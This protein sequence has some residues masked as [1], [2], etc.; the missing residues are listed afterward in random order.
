MTR[1]LFLGPLLLTLAA[2]DRGADERPVV[3]DAIEQDGNGNT[4]RVL[5][6]SALAQGLVRFD[7]AG[8]VEPAIAERWNMVDDGRSYI[9]RL[10]TATWSDGRPV[11]AD[12][13][14]TALRRAARTGAGHRLT[15][16]LRSIDEIV[17]M[18][19]QV[20]EIRLKRPNTELLTLLAQP[21]LAVMHGAQGSGPMRRLR[22][23]G[24][25]LRAPVDSDA[26]APVPADE[27]RLNG[28]RAALAV[29]RFGAKRSDLVLGGA[30]ADWPIVAAAGL[31]T[32]D[33]R[34]DP[35]RGLFGFAFVGRDGFLAAPLNRAAVA[36]AIQTANLPAAIDGGWAGID[37][38]LPEAFDSASDPALPPWRKLTED[39]RWQTARAQVAAWGRPVTVRVAL[40]DGPGATLLWG[41]MAAAL[42][43]TG[44]H[45]QR[46]GIDAPA[47]LLLIDRVAPYDSA[48]WYLA[49]ACRGCAM[50][51]M[52]LIAAARDA[53]SLPERA[54]RLAAA[55]AALAADVAFVAVARPWRWSLV[56]PRL[57]GFQ[58]NPRGVHPLNHLRGDT[59]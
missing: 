47:D 28:A 14:V 46:V 17:A 4:E 48:R 3:V 22:G 19:P 27:V 16:F 53:T 30:L 5:L 18:T 56:A 21:E 26:P 44:I 7:A 41:R 59:K 34:V 43:R 9:F 39:Q 35:A 25:R 29:A 23:Q 2:C 15:P 33:I 31:R 50:D 32:T 49:T 11:T 38:I 51:A 40:P 55:D 52:T 1:L 36:M 20:I 58:T 12:Q 10:G 37:T 6:R 57:R 45:G 8:Q 24:V 42:A 13:V 54:Q